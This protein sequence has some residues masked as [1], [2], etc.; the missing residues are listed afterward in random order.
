MP[1]GQAHVHPNSCSVGGPQGRSERFRGEK[2]F[3]SLT[4][5]EPPDRSDRSLVTTRILT[6]L[7]RVRHYYY[8]YY[9][10]NNTQEGAPEKPSRYSHWTVRGSNP[11][12]GR[13]FP[14]PSRP[15]LVPTQ[16]PVQWVPG[17]SRG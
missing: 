6:T 7:S 9:Y 5:C 12:G 1:R 17:L 10:C 8:Y 4:E 16:P 2:H 14:Q 11:S 3:L 15:A 13:D